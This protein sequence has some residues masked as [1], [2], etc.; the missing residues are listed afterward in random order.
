MK[1]H[2]LIEILKKKPQNADVVINGKPLRSIKLER[3]QSQWDWE[4]RSGETEEAI[5]RWREQREED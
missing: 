5:E 1:V 4:D 2:E 3:K